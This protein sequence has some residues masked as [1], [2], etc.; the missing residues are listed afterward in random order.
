M[1]PMW[2]WES[3]A[4]SE[5]HESEKRK[6]R[7]SRRRQRERV[8]KR[9]GRDVRSGGLRNVEKLADRKVKLT[10][11][12]LRFGVM[13]ALLMIFI[14]PIGVIVLICR[15]PPL[16][17]RFYRMNVEPRLRERFIEDEV[18][19]QVRQ[20]LS[21]ERRALEGEHARSMAAPALRSARRRISASPWRSKLPAWPP[22]YS[23]SG[24]QG[25]VSGP[26]Q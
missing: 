3:D 20:T 19:K 5:S 22:R 15:G 24:S 17:R 26:R 10:G 13:V 8:R 25:E 6:H 23:S 12:T 16:L 2:E 1:S 18:R 11:D 4:D 14:W 9:D 7:K 21:R